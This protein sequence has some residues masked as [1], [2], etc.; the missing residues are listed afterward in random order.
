MAKLSKPREGSLQFWPRV[1]ATK[2]LP[3][4]NWSVV[5]A[6][7]K[8]EGLLGFIGYK[9]GMATA[10][11]KDSTDK[12]MT[13]GKKITIPVTI[14]E[15]P[16]LKVYAVRFYHQGLVVKDV[17]VAIDKELKKL[18]KLPAEPQKIEPPAQFDDVRVL[19]YSLVKQ[20]DL[21]KTPDIAEVAVNAANKLE[22]VKG[23]I[24]RDLAL[25]ELAV[26]PLVDVRGLTTGKGFSGAVKRFGIS[27]KQHK[28]EKGRRR[29]GSLGPWHPARVTFRTPMAGQLGMFSRV[30]YNLNV[31]T[32]NSIA[33]KN[34]N[35]GT[36]F[37]NYGQV[38]TSYIILHG[39][40]QGPAKRQILLTPALRPTKTQAKKKYEFQELIV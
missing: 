14:L 11:V 36:G 18:V 1:R 23:L 40:V 31:I 10:L 25:K 2:A 7:S 16:A 26:Y 30:H 5:K 3:R 33:E 12:S 19:I 15:V 22:Y 37:K 32:S 8:K 4:V 34:I 35:P 21:K 24:G 28:S 20:S 6:D 39:S 9:V 38:K 17:V 13:S 27:L 29:P